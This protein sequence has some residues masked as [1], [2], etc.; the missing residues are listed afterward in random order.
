MSYEH[1]FS[2][3]N[4]GNLTIKNRLIAGPATM[5]YAEEDGKINERLLEFYRHKALGGI[6]MIVVEGAYISAEC[7]GYY[8]QISIESDE[9]IPGLAK[10][11]A[12]IK[13][14]GAA[15]SIQIQHCGRR[16]KPKLTGVQPMGPSAIPYVQDAPVPREMTEEDIQTAIAQFAAAAERAKKAGFDSVDI[17]SAHGY[18]PAAFISP[19]ANKRTDKWG[20]DLEQRCSFVV[21]VVKAIKA[22]VGEDFPVTIKISA[23]EF[24]HGGVT[25]EDTIVVAKKLEEAGIAAIQVSA[26]APGDDNIVDLDQPV[27]FMRTM[28][29][30][31]S[32]GC[33][34][35]LAEEVKKHVSIP[36]VTLGRMN[37][38]D[39]A[40]QVLADGKADMISLTR[41]LLTDPYWPVKVQEGR[42][43]DIRPCISCNEGCYNRILSGEPI[44]CACNP[45]VGD[46]YLHLMENKGDPKKV[47]VIGGGVC[48]L[49]AALTSKELGNE[50][51]LLEKTDKLGGQLWLAQAP[52]DRGEIRK[53]A[54]YM[55]RAVHK[56]GVDIRMNTEATKELLEELQPDR[57]IIATGSSP[58]VPAAMCKNAD[59]ITAHEILDKMLTFPGKTA[60]VIG[61]GLVG[62]ETADYLAQTGSKVTMVEMMPKI[63]GESVKE[64]RMFFD[65]KFQKYGVTVLTS[66]KV[67]ELNGKN[68]TIT[69]PEGTSSADY[70][71]LVLAI[72]S[73][74]SRVVPGLD[75]SESPET[76]ELAGKTVEVRYGGDSIRAR[77][78]QSAMMEGYQAAL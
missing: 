18:L 14:N 35:Y 21:E 47:V 31:T 26:G 11:A 59:Y 46:E 42:L 28:P 2:P 50:T 16:A 69:T 8:R 60:M 17:H 9:M 5:S 34:N 7:K 72:G 29:M 76:I 25:I 49:Q 78:I 48:G 12:V 15:A 41:Q 32:H 10:L 67:E 22:K 38:A 13:E 1:I 71:L 36:V 43:E 62:C 3:I 23:D 54:E 40:E 6:G 68:A 51:V 64:E 37:N 30:A 19:L 55:V 70:D 75:F 77:K 33:L 56:A 45:A 24:V 63:A 73:R 44:G 52:P 65:L 58:V 66:T 20:G 57:I 61:G 27:T 4:I 74:A 53:I 39:V